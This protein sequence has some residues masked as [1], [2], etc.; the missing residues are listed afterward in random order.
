MKPSLLIPAVMLLT[1]S[2]TPT[3]AAPV[4]YQI[5]PSHTYPSIEVDHLG[6]VS[7]WRGKFN[8]TS[9]QI[10]LDTE[11]KTGMVDIAVDINSL[12]FG[13]DTMNYHVLS[14]NMLNAVKFPVA[15]YTGQLAGFTEGRPSTVEGQF[16]LRGITQPLTLQIQQFKCIQHPM[17]KR[18]VCGADAIGNFNRAD[19]GIDYGKGMG[20]NMNVLL[21]I[22]VEALKAD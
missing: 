2:A 18:E 6:G 3:W 17:L 15:H 9:G 11:E 12:D 13:H 14:A 8:K 20:F 7:I 4:N 16:T 10:Q 1:L 5:D 19:F 21:R 22:Q